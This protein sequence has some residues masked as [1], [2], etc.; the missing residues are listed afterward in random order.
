ML[1]AGTVVLKN[2]MTLRNSLYEVTLYYQGKQR[3][4]RALR[5]T[6]NQL[7]EPYGHQPVHILEQS[8]CREFGEPVSEVLYVPFCSVGKE[9]GILAA[10]RMDRMEV[11][12]QE[13]LVRVLERPWV[14]ISETPLSARHKY[15][16]LLH[17]EL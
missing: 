2:G 14:A 9:H 16:M 4:V 1:W 10:V 15:E 11:W 8:V 6:G 17:G 7:Y 5:D 13:R 3:T 12:Q